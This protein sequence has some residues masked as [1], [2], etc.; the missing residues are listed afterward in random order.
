MEMLSDS[1][2]GGD[3]DTRISVTGY[4]L[5]ILGALVL[6]KS[7]AQTGIT[8]SSSEAEYVAMSEAAKEIQFVTQLLQSLGIKVKTPIIVRVDNIGAIFMGE[9]I[10][11]SQK[12]KHVD[13]RYKFVN[14]FVMDKFIKI[15]FVKTA[16]N[17]ADIFTKNVTG[18]L[19]KKHT[20]DMIGEVKERKLRQME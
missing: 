11:T 14:E 8:L 7:K 15:I 10:N 4:C 20:R 5:Y 12:T 13:I 1:D 3:P 18:E 19:H 2:Y 17:K 6:W 9:N 16:E